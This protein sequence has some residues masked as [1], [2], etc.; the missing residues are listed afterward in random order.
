MIENDKGSYLRT[1]S[2]PRCVLLIFAS[3]AFL[4]A[5]IW[6]NSFIIDSYLVSYLNIIP[7]FASLFLLCKALHIERYVGEHSIILFFLLVCTLTLISLLF[8]SNYLFHDY[9]SGHSTEIS[10]HYEH[11]WCHESLVFVAGSITDNNVDPR[12]IILENLIAPQYIVTFFYS[13]V[14]FIFGGDIVTN[15]CVWNGMHLAVMAILV[16]LIAVKMGIE[17]KTQMATILL[18]SLIMPAFNMLY[19]YDRDIIGEFFLILGFFIFI[20]AYKKGPKWCLLLLP[21][22]GFFFFALRIQY[23]L[24]AVVLCFSSFISRFKTTSY[25]FFIAFLI[26]L[27]LFWLYNSGLW[28]G[29]NFEVYVN[30]TMEDQRGLIST[31]LVGIIGYFPWTN[32][33]DDPNVSYHAPLCIQAAVDLTLWYYFYLTYRGNFREWIVNPVIFGSLILTSF[34]FIGGAGHIK[35]FC[36]SAPLFLMLIKGVNLQKLIK[37]YIFVIFGYISV[38]ML[39]TLFKM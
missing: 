3:I 29:L 38:S 4:L 15:W 21:V 13:S 31:I 25:L 5:G 20:C 18:G 22:Y 19:I 27:V 16:L 8:S 39:Y 36:I 10:K 17:N 7:L 33:L 28:E 6:I 2:L 32:L 34:G 30:G 26:P 35:Y 1:V 9:L 12:E 14:L 11:N 37:S 24:V 23:I